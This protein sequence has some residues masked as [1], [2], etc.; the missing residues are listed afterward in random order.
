MS[1]LTD[2][3]TKLNSCGAVVLFQEYG[4]AI[5]GIESDAIYS[6]VGYLISKHLINNPIE[7]CYKI[8][9]LSNFTIHSFSNILTVNLASRGI[10]SNIY[11]SEY[12]QYESELLDYAS[13]IYSEK[14][15]MSVLLLDDHVI[16]DKLG[17]DWSLGNIQLLCSELEKQIEAYISTFRMKSGSVFVLST[18]PL[19]VR[20]Q[21]HFIDFS[22]RSKLRK[23][24]NIMNNAIIDLASKYND[25]V[26]IDAEAILQ[27]ECRLSDDAMHY[28]AKQY[29]SDKMLRKFCDEVTKIAGAILGKNKKCLVVDLDNTLWDGI[30]GDDGWSGVEFDSSKFG[31]VFLDMHRMLKQWSRQGLLLAVSSKNDRTAFDHLLEKRP[32]FILDKSDFVGF[33]VNWDPKS[34]NILAL[35]EALNISTDSMVF[36]DDS[37][38]ERSE[39]RQNLSDVSVLEVG[40]NPMLY[41]RALFESGMFDLLSTNVEDFNR[42][43]MY[44]AE[45]SRQEVMSQA[46]SIDDFLRKLNM[47]L[48]ISIAE[49][50]DFTR[51]SQLTTRTNQFNLNK[52]ELSTDSLLKY[53]NNNLILK[54]VYE[55]RYGG[56]GIVGCMLLRIGAENE[57]LSLIIDNFVLSC[58]VFSRGIEEA[59]LQVVISL[60]EKKNDRVTLK[61]LYKESQKNKRFSNFYVKNGFSLIDQLNDQYI[62]Q[63]TS[64]Q[65]QDFTKMFLVETNIDVFQVSNH[66]KVALGG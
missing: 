62:Y 61:A 38:F 9:L 15:L 22:S 41:P 7:D 36:I 51:I 54:I 3:R 21:N 53:S 49:P 35:S 27:S 28:Y 50:S 63:Y 43:S 14:Y 31:T 64:V 40:E 16:S 48:E 58:K 13:E 4:D 11:I 65:K 33:H 45:I 66:H 47:K 42:V 30:L 5:Y 56:N 29:F 57:L 20:L 23:I 59:V 39:V 37:S 25:V 24:W 44:H 1:I 2:I 12:S 19:S 10:W 18:I 46:T 8:A 26:I 32:D 52:E 6:Q 34:A 60:I 55:D 17:D